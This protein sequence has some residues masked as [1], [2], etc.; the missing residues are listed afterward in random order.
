MSYLAHGTSWLLRF[1]LGRTGCFL[2]L[3][4]GRRDCLLRRDRRD[5]GGVR[6]RGRGPLKTSLTGSPSY[7]YISEAFLCFY[8]LLKCLHILSRNVQSGSQFLELLSL[9][10]LLS[11]Q[12]DKAQLLSSNIGP[13]KEKV[14]FH[15]RNGR[16]L[17]GEEKLLAGN[18]SLH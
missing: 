11:L 18:W 17:V 10:G 1:W 12:R 15:G 14:L 5:V 3:L 13:H 2:C 7:R 8:L 9:L 4:V 16:V 6:G